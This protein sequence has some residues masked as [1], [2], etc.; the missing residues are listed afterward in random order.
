MNWF[1]TDM[2]DGRSVFVFGSNRQGRHGIGAAQYAKNF[3]GAV[4]GRG[5]GRQGRAYAIPV[6]DSPYDT[7]SLADIKIHVDTFLEYARTH[8]RLRFLVTEIG[9]GHGGYAPSQI[10]PMFTDAPANCVLTDRFI[11]VISGKA[12]AK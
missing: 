3:W 6:K 11:E 4:N 1:T 5:E 12:P 7:L 9:T 2:D 10:A 8:R